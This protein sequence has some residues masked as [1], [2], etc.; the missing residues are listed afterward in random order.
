MGISRFF[1]RQLKWC[2]GFLVYH[3][4]LFAD[5][6][7][8]YMA[9][10]YTMPKKGGWLFRSFRGYF[11]GSVIYKRVPQLRTALLTGESGRLWAE[12]YRSQ[13]V[14]YYLQEFHEALEVCVGV[15]KAAD[16]HRFLQVGCAGG[17]ELS[18]LAGQFPSVQFR[19][20]DI[21]SGA[22]EENRKSYASL[23]NLE[24]RVADLTDRD[25]WATWGPD[26]I[27]SSGCLEYLT[28]SE[29]AEFFRRA[30]DSGIRYLII[31]EPTDSGV[32]QHSV[33]RGGGA[34][35]H[36]YPD[37]VTRSGWPSFRVVSKPPQKNL[38]LV[39]SQEPDDEAANH[40]RAY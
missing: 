18:M 39:A 28:E 34:F 32:Q 29:V 7:Q 23:G 24:F 4:P 14:E 8:E 1:P 15:L 33:P 6:R 19:G 30:C 26:V 31:F 38:L 21:S 20:I 40:H 5:L 36:D 16:I 3:I 2:G 27:Y 9:R 10:L 35:A 37:L 11:L 17:R 25:S 12:F 22:I 13:S